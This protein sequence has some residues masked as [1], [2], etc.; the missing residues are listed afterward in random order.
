MLLY[1]DHTWFIGG[2]EKV[3]ICGDVGYLLHMGAKVFR[4]VVGWYK[5]ITRLGSDRIG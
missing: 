5:H 3:V 1:S 4:P 2:E